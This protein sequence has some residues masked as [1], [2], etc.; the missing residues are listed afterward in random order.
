MLRDVSARSLATKNY[1]GSAFSVERFF[2]GKCSIMV[3]SLPLK[4]IVSLAHGLGRL[5]V[6]KR[7]EEDPTR[8]SKQ[9]AQLENLNR[10]AG[11]KAW[12]HNQWALKQSQT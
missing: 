5:L 11:R 4:I 10:V 9:L 2:M 6:K 8:D 12:Q 7:A 1:Q 3:V